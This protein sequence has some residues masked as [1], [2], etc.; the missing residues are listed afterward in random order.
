[1]VRAPQCVSILM[2]SSSDEVLRGSGNSA[3]GQ[4]L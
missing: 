1:M 3:K 4:C 2:V